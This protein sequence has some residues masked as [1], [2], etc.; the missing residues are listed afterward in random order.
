MQ[1]GSVSSPCPSSID[2]CTTSLHD[3]LSP[4]VSVTIPLVIP[5]QAVATLGSVAHPA[6]LNWSQIGGFR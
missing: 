3:R 2:A 1:R 5:G 4:L 6:V